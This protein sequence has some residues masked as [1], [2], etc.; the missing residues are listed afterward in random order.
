[1]AELS[2]PRGPESSRL[3]VRETVRERYAAARAVAAQR[4]S[5]SCCGPIALTDA[6]ESRVFGAALYDEAQREGA[7]A[8]ALAASLGCGVPTAVADLH[9][10][11]TVLNLGSAPVRGFLQTIGTRQA[12][13]CLLKDTCTLWR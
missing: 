12:R 9:E 2:E 5:A 11:E 6:D 10:G 13:E 3:G 1:M 7:S 4:A 8:P